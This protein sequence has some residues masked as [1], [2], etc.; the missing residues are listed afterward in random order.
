MKPDDSKKQ[1]SIPVGAR[2]TIQDEGNTVT[3][4]VTEFHG[5][6]RWY[7]RWYHRRDNTDN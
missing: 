5:T 3:G 6:G 1:I 4:I 7:H 2:V